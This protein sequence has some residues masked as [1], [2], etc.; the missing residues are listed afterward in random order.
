MNQQ[1]AIAKKDRHV[2]M[3]RSLGAVALKLGTVA[4]ARL[5]EQGKTD[6]VR[7]AVRI[8]LATA[9]QMVCQIELARLYDSFSKEVPEKTLTDRLR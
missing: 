7:R 6:E 9:K 4:K 2:R 5:H 3:A 1:E 8:L